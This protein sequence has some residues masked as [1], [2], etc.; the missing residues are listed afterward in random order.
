MNLEPKT[1]SDTW[2]LLCVCVCARC[3]CSECEWDKACNQLEEN[4]N[5][6]TQKTKEKVYGE[7]NMEKWSRRK[8]GKI[9]WLNLTFFVLLEENRIKKNSLERDST[10]GRKEWLSHSTEHCTRHVNVWITMHFTERDT[11]GALW[12][13]PRTCVHRGYLPVSGKGHARGRT[14]IE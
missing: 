1:T 13:P 3:A 7:D 14:K 9:K 11:N 4:G 5:Q 10:C 2:P 8:K 6:A 12:S